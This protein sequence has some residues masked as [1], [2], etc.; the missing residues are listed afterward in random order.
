MTERLSS[1]PLEAL[2][3]GLRDINKAEVIKAY[4]IAQALGCKVEDLIEWNE[5]TEDS[6]SEK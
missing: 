6:E 5:D 2:E 3:Q 4:R 1:R